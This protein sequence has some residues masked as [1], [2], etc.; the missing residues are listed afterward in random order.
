MRLSLGPCPGGLGLG[1]FQL[2]VRDGNLPAP[3][4]ALGLAV[5]VELGLLPG[6]PPGRVG[7]VDLRERLRLRGGFGHLGIGDR[8]PL[9]QAALAEFPRGGHRRGF[10]RLRAPRP[11]RGERRQLPAG[12][13]A[14]RRGRAP[15]PRPTW[16]CCIRRLLRLLHLPDGDGTLTLYRVKPCAD[17]GGCDSYGAFPFGQ[18]RLEILVAHRRHQRP[19]VGELQGDAEAWNISR[20]TPLP[21]GTGPIACLGSVIPAASR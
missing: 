20:S 2:G 6:L 5:S 3:P 4:F 15:G 17:V 13:R 8:D 1:G 11:T 16:P 19:V 21:A 10:Q 9:G 18:A 14:G 12:W 7:R